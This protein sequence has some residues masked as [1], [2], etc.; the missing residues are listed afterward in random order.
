TEGALLNNRYP[1]ANLRCISTQ[2]PRPRDPHRPANPARH[3]PPDLQHRTHPPRPSATHHPC[4]GLRRTTQ[5][6]PAR[7]HHRKPLPHPPRHCRQLRQTPPAL[8]HPTPPTRHRH[9]PRRHQSPHHR[10]HRQRHRVHHT[11]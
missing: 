10:H 9:R 5:S 7:P 6:S 8:R 4:T 2:R 1:L 3:L 11:R